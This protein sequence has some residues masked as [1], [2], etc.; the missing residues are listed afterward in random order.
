MDEVFLQTVLYDEFLLTI[1]WQHY[2][3]H[4]QTYDDSCVDKHLNVDD[5]DTILW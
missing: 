1:F 3:K 5:A 4:A 2:V